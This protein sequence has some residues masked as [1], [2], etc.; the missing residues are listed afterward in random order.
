[1]PMSCHICYTSTGL[2]GR[3]QRE[4]RRQYLRKPFDER[5]KNPGRRRRLEGRSWPLGGAVPG[6]ENVLFGDP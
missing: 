5:R 4:G 3:G 2:A 6:R 1:M